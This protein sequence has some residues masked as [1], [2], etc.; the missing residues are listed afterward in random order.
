M[1]LK[2]TDLYVDRS[3]SANIMIIIEIYIGKNND[4]NR[5]LGGLRGKGRGGGR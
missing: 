3:I 1:E 4:N 2:P 5:G